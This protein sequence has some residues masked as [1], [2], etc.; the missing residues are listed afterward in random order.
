MLL[1]STRVAF[2]G[3][4]VGLSVALMFLTG[5]IPIATY[6][7]PAL[8]GL[9]C[10]AVVIEMGARWAWPVYAAASVLSVFLAGDKEAVALFI[11][12][13]GYY[14]ILKSYLERFS[15]HVLSWVL[16]FAVFNAAMMLGYFAAVYLLGVPKDSFVVFGFFVPWLLLAAGNAVFFLYDYAVSGIVVAYYRRFHRAAAKWLRMK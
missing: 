15:S 8:A 2:C 4:A 16:K 9:P 7:L 12:F 3:L 11:L 13:F 14:P 5:M 1:K 10:I 6:A